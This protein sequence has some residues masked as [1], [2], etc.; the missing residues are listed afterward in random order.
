MDIRHAV[1]VKTGVPAEKLANVLTFQE[2]PRFSAR[3]RAALHF[4]ER[5]TRDDLEV[6]G[7]VPGSGSG[8]FYRGGDPGTDVHHRLS[9]LC[10]QIREGLED[11]ASGLLVLRHQSTTP[12][13]D[14]G[15]DS[16]RVR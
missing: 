12:W 9:D 2:S 14:L 8:A 4:S 7:R 15:D 11:R 16:P 3:E 6:S 13:S 5:I 1:G 10:Q